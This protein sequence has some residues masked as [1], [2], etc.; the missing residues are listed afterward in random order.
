MPAALTGAY[1]LIMPEVGA[2]QDIWGGELN[3][4]ISMIDGL[5]AN[6][7]IL[8]HTGPDSIAGDPQSIG[9]GLVVKQQA[10][11]PAGLGDMGYEAV[12]TARWVEKRI[13]DILNEWLPY[14]VIMLWY[15][16]TVNP[17]PKGWRLCNGLNGTPNFSDRIILSAGSIHEAGE[18]GGAPN[19]GLGE[20]THQATANLQFGPGDF[21]AT[22]DYGGIALYAGGGGA[23]ADLPYYTACYIMKT[24]TWPDP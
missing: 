12:T 10:G 5:L 16:A 6:R 18:N 22:I 19:V 23:F 17:M 11:Y 20:H 9:T 24:Q 1:K 15:G 14:G 21:D 2:D 13:F 7:V 4:T 8:N 3:Q